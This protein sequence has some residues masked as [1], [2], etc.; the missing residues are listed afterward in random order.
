MT[1]LAAV[2][3]VVVLFIVAGWLLGTVWALARLA[4]LA[5]AVGGV[6]WAVRV[7]RA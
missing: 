6:V 2:V 1:M 7:M 4:L 3:V 5:A